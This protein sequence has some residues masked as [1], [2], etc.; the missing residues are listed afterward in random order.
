MRNSALGRNVP[1][2]IADSIDGEV[3]MIDLET[4]S[5]YSLNGTGAEVWELFEVPRSASHIVDTLAAR[6]NGV[7]QDTVR[8]AVRRFVEALSDAELLV[9]TDM[10]SGEEAPTARQEPRLDFQAPTLTAYHDMQDLLLLDP[11]HEV[12]QGGWPF[13]V[14]KD[15]PSEPNP[16]SND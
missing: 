7:D 11:V 12:D 3:I 14:P 10:P 16:R 5:Y 15:S 1:R 4:G 9:G 6:Y 2:I 8:E 13:A